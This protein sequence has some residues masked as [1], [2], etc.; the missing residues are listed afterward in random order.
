MSQY[1]LYSTA[2]IINCVAVIA[3]GFKT[4]PKSLI[5]LIALLKIRF[6]KSISR[7]LWNYCGYYLSHTLDP[8]GELGD[9][10][11]TGFA[12]LR[13]VKSILTKV[14][15]VCKVVYRRVSNPL[16]PL[17]LNRIYNE[18]LE[19]PELQFS[20]AYKLVFCTQMKENIEE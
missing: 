5:L 13:A 4:F 19:K 18:K 2:K 12:E 9:K 20:L 10:F 15:R 17:M 1:K 11:F 6:F 16:V 7:H 3:D 14:S 8:K